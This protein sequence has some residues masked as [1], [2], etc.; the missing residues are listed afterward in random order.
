MHNCTPDAF[1]SIPNDMEY[2]AVLSPE[3]T[4]CQPTPIRST[5]PEG[6]FACSVANDPSP[7]QMRKAVLSTSLV[8]STAANGAPKRNS[9]AETSSCETPFS[10][11][12]DSGS[13]TPCGI[14]VSLNDSRISL[15]PTENNGDIDFDIDPEESSF[16]DWESSLRNTTQEEATTKGS[17]QLT[18]FRIAICFL[19]IGVLIRELTIP[20]ETQFIQSAIDKIFTRGMG[21]LRYEVDSIKFAEMEKELDAVVPELLTTSSALQ[22]SQRQ[23]EAAYKELELMRE[24]LSKLEEQIRVETTD[25]KLTRDNFTVSLHSLEQATL[26]LKAKEV[27]F[28]VLTQNLAQLEQELEKWKQ[29]HQVA[30]A[31]A[32]NA[33][34]RKEI[35][36]MDLEK[37]L[38][39]LKHPESALHQ[40]QEAQTELNDRLVS[41]RADHFETSLERDELR[42]EIS[43]LQLLIA[44]QAQDLVDTRNEMNTLSKVSTSLDR[45]LRESL[46]TLNGL[47][48][49]LTTKTRSLEKL[50]TQLS[51]T[52]MELLRT[53]NELIE[54]KESLSRVDQEIRFHEAVH[55]KTKDEMAYNLSELWETQIALRDAIEVLLEFEEEIENLHEE[56]ATQERT[57]AHAINFVTTQAINEQQ[58][59]AAQV[60]NF[61]TTFASQYQMKVQ[62]EEAEY[63][64]TLTCASKHQIMAP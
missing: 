6:D 37:S 59:A 63:V 27:Q 38:D 22:E 12:P 36:A 20:E 28:V 60:V 25:G 26:A 18:L 40:S 5:E 54:A 64:E 50:E 31:E 14:L 24:S 30:L 49:E 23:V 9:S 43:N 19:L 55:V 48:D 47:Q 45:Q 33:V 52:T 61:M 21:A 3:S 44:S 39:L 34:N 15:V 4:N 2:A 53:Q 56:L 16:R 41:A 46:D 11:Q 7:I 58:R 29:T 35:M 8:S 57:V 51:V 32:E 1:K 62:T 42:D 13:G 10:Q 17:W